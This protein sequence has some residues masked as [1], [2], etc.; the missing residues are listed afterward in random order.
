MALFTGVFFTAYRGQVLGWGTELLKQGASE[1][2]DAY[3]FPGK[4]G[5]SDLP[6]TG[7][8]FKNICSTAVRRDYVI[9]EKNKHELENKKEGLQKHLLCTSTQNPAKHFQSSGRR[10]PL[11]FLSDGNN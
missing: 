9:R 7:M 5:V 2:L 10:L 11:F 6:T 8:C 4:C 3:S 1:I